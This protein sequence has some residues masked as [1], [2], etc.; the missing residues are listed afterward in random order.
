MSLR[1]RLI[2]LSTAWLIFILVLFNTLLYWLIVNITAKSEKELL[3]GKAQS[4]LENRKIH[5]PGYWGASDLLEDFLVSDEMIRIIDMD[6]LIRQE[7]ESNEI[8]G[9]QQPH[10]T[11]RESYAIK[12]I[13]KTRYLYVQ[14]PIFA[15][16]E[17]IGVLEIAR[18]LTKW[19]LYINVLT[20]ALVL[21]TIG[22][23]TISV[24]GSLFYTR[25][26]LQPLRQLNNT[27]QLIQQSGTFRKLD[28]EFT[29]RTDELGK[30][31]IT[32]NEMISRLEELVQKQKRFVADAS[33]ELRTPLTIIESYANML[34]RWGGGDPEIRKEAIEA[35]LGESNRLKGLV[36]TLMQLAES[37]QEDWLQFAPVELM[38]V[39][40][41]AAS[42]MELAF[43]RTIRVESEADSVPIAGDPEKLKQL[44]LILLDN[45]I[46]YSSK[47]VRIRVV[48]GD[49][50]V[51]IQVIDQ[52]IGLEEN[53]LPFIFD[54][55][56]RTDRAR[57]RQTGGFGLGLA[58]AKSI[59]ERHGGTIRM[60]SRSGRGT[61][62][63]VSLP[64]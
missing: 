45:A 35:I 63:T 3:F 23:V 52:G 12:R 25:F 42:A 32:F 62:V 10:V 18:V 14:V 34:K 58:I 37:E 43:D 4:I 40:R 29:A 19:S 11:T 20:S 6:G 8:L 57:T 48:P 53:M 56:F 24:I 2:V 38:A 22:A 5:D 17:Q 47:P 16:N 1:V 7:V 39:I 50:T 27:M 36:G 41:S 26:L 30:L 55:F 33:H 15:G 9:V 51:R 28:R 64:S 46:K 31:G 44:L 59:V 61:I 21:M 49:G 13:E 54:R 60:A